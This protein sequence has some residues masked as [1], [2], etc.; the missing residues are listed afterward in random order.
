MA[1]LRAQLHDAEVDKERLHE[2]LVTA[3]K[4]LDRVRSKT[5]ATL[6]PTE[7][8]SPP[9]EKQEHVVKDESPRDTPSSPAVSGSVLIGGRLV[10]NCTTLLL[11][12]RVAYSITFCAHY[13]QW[14]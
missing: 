10:S 14:P 11:T 13:R 2:Q 6:Y 1:H 5:L 12:L 9:P 7:G 4:R 3:E 8:A